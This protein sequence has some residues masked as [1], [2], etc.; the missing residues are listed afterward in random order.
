LTTILR[1]KGA[2]QQQDIATRDLPLAIGFSDDGFFAF[3]HNAEL[4]AAAYLGCVDGKLFVQ[5]ETG[6]RSVQLNGI[7]LDESA[8]LVAGD[9]IKIGQKS[10]EVTSDAGVLALSP[11]EKESPE[12]L[13][14]SADSTVENPKSEGSPAGPDTVPVGP[15]GPLRGRRSR[16]RGFVASVGLFVGLLIGVV[17]VIAAS[18]IRVAV[19][20]EPDS[21]SLSGVPPPIPFGGRY[22][23]LPGNYLVVAE[24]VGYRKLERQ[25]TVE[26]GSEPEIIYQLQKLPGYLDVISH[27]VASARVTIDGQAVGQ[28]PLSS[29]ELEAG[30][31]E[32][33]VVADRY[34]PTTKTI[35]VRGMGDRQTMEVTLLPGWGTLEIASEPSETEVRL[36]GMAIGFTPL[37][38]NPMAGAYHLELRKSGWKPVSREITIKA[39]ETVILPLIQLEKVD[40]TLNLTTSPA[41]ATVMVNDEL[42]GRSPIMLT[43]KSGRDH[44]I[45]ISKVGYETV[46]RKVSFDGHGPKSLNIDLTP[47]YGI[48]FLNTR[49]AGAKL[50]VDGK[51]LGSASRRLRLTTAPHRFEITKPGYV[52]HAMTVTPRRGVSKKF[53]VELEKIQKSQPNFVDAEIRTAAGQTLRLIQLKK[54]IRFK[55]GASRREA[56]RRANEVQYSVELTRSYY[57]GEKEVTNSEFQMFDNQ[58]DSGTEQ[59]SDLSGPNQPVVSVSWDDAARYM[60]WLSK[61][62]GLPPAYHESNGKIVAADLN[63]IGYRLPTETEWTFAARYEGGQRLADDPLKFPW[64]GGMPPPDNSGN[65][66]D[67]TAAG[68]LPII[69]REYSDGYLF[70]AP[71]GQFPA[72]KARIYDLAGNIAEWTHD[73]YDV[74]TGGADQVL[75][76]PTGPKTGDLHVVRGASWRHGSITELR[77]SYRD[78]ALKPRNDL[79][80]RIARYATRPSK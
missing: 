4:G 53:D 36:D 47:K 7:T 14:N 12:K 30:Q 20:P 45:T 27:P 69:V 68:M 75:R 9:M 38:A 5:P 62:D 73:Y 46:S 15:I 76:D 6:P 57:I 78:Y 16:S 31:H 37:R 67:E 17:F 40:G 24:K 28:T 18:P 66:A 55:M 65:Y 61:K 64:G 72:N 22:L 80:F 21:I 23:A 29:L 50:K 60:N 79:G 13:G 26:F 34:L 43:L 1:I 49:P 70:A 35:D 56:G 10:I 48:V 39:N 44:K 52:T 74:Y 3:G 2:G 33:R 59:G 54:P 8:W 32:L 77:L 19:S 41:G 58:H 71:V 63:A 42:R 25:I 11:I 51:L